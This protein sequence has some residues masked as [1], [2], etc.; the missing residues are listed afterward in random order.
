MSVN[1]LMIN[2]VDS[3]V[4]MSVNDECE[5]TYDQY[6]VDSIVTMSVINTVN[7]ILINYYDYYL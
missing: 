6:I 2:I 7:N 3:I 1:I 5:H 4:T